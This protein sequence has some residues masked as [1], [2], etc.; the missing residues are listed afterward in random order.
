MS[1]YDYDLFVIGIGSGG[2][3]AARMIASTGARVAA[4]EE[5]YYG[6]TC[7]NVGCVPKKLLVYGSHFHEDFEDAKAYGWDVT[8]G[9][10]DW[11][12]LIEKK[13]TEI[14]RLNGIYRKLLDNAGVSVYDARA[15]IV[16]QH[17]LD[18]GGEKITTDRILIAVGG[19]PTKPDVP[20]IEHAITSNEVFYLDT[21]PKRFVVVGGGYIAV[22]FAGIMNGMGADVTQLYRSEQILRGFDGD[23]RETLSKE[24]VK[25]GIDLRVNTNITAIEK[26]GGTLIATLTDGS[27]LEADCIMYATGRHPNTASLGLENIGVEMDRSGAIKVDSFSKTNVDNVWALGDVTDRIA[28]TPVA[29]HEAMCFYRTEY[30]GDPTP[31][32][33]E[34]VASAVFSQ[35][36]VG[37]VGITEAQAR[38]KYGE[39][40]I[41]RS[42]FTAMKHTISGRDEKTLMKIIVDQAS[43]K[44]VGVH[45]VG[46]DAGEIIQGIG[47]AVKMGATKQDFDRTIG[48]HPTS[49]EEFVT[50]RE[51][52][53]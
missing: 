44:V 8:V 42:T 30:L 3:R 14:E 1:D 15:T 43:Q 20:G 47:I 31:S 39:I 33:H 28:L 35:P 27:K 38:E 22:E 24:I 21:F 40:D 2:T 9:D 5:R 51:K 11:N 23:V 41:Y 53:A 45:M 12:M 34:N 48:I 7:V 16:D 46:P 10:F 26:D 29:I 49:A 37:T 13:N 32:D 50:M 19:W 4:A 18:V 6:G 36:P 17:T 52:A 25:K